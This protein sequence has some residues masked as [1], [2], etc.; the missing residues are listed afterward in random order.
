MA[1]LSD[2]DKARMTT[3]AKVEATL[4]E[5]EAILHTAHGNILSTLDKLRATRKMRG[6]TGAPLI[7][8]GHLAGAAAGKPSI[9]ITDAELKEGASKP[10][11]GEGE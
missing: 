3:I 7:V 11:G 5:N 8:P 9:I 2:R 10:M 6:G 4:P 1:K